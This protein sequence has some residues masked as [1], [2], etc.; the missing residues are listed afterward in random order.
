MQEKWHGQ[1]DLSFKG[2]FWKDSSPE[3]LHVGEK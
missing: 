1:S 3:L 2:L